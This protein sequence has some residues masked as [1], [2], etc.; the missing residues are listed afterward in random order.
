M[1]IQIVARHL[2]PRLAWM[3]LIARGLVVIIF[4]QT[5]YFKFSAAPESVFIFS[6]LA[7]EP[8]GRLAIGVFEGFAVLLLVANRT[9]AFGAI[10]SVF[11]MLGAVACHVLFLGVEVQHD[12]GLLFALALIAILA[13]IIVLTLRARSFILVEKERTGDAHKILPEF[14]RLIAGQCRTLP[15]ISGAPRVIVV[16]GG[17][18]GLEIVRAL[19]NSK[20]EVLLFDKRNYHLFQPLLYQVATAALNPSQIAIPLRMAAERQPNTSIYLAEVQKVDLSRKRVFVGV[21]GTEYKYDYLVLAAGVQTNY[22]GRDEFKTNAPGMKTIE[23]ALA[24][25]HRFLLA[26]EEAEMVRDMAERESILT[27]VIVGGGPTGVELAGTMA[28]IAHHTLECSF[29]RFSATSARVILIDSGDRI[30][31][32]FPSTCSA[33]AHKDLSELGVEIILQARVTDVTSDAVTIKLKDGSTSTIAARHVTWAAGVLAV[34]LSRTLGVELDSVG[35][36]KVAADLSIPDFPECF[37]IGDLAHYQD[38]RTGR[39]VPGVAQG[40]IQMGSFVG[41][42]LAREIRQIHSHSRS[43]NTTTRG[44]FSY[45]DKGSLATIGRGRAVAHIGRFQLAGLGAWLIWAIVHVSFL[46][47]LRNRFHICVQWIWMFFFY[48][49]G[50]RLITREDAHM[51]ISRMPPDPRLSSSS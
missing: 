11:L 28:E 17:F 48:E 40:A 30:L 49:L 42:I 31:K 51:S 12:N 38:R 36:I 26:F 41:K 1:S 32:A 33:R 20:A 47:G 50:V 46:K 37:V 6:A 43:S 14:N 9:A 15:D 22:F 35:R 2:R 25:R 3:D 8:V 19:R 24:V 16:G 5:L 29:R 21:D 23:E 13:A 44:D 4:S 10:L 18:G 39:Q 45:F 7:A 34:P 27:F